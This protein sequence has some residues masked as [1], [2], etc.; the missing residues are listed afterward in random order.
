LRGDL[1]VEAASG[2]LRIGDGGD[3]LRDGGGLHLRFGGELN[4]R[5]VG[6]GGTLC[7]WRLQPALDEPC[8]GNKG[9][10]DEGTSIGA[11]GI[12]PVNNLQLQGQVRSARD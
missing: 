11:G 8:R 2:D 5:I 7:R 4:L 1:G 6:G 3:D 9:F 12:S 10:S